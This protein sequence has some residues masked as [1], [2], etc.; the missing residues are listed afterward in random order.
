[1]DIAIP[2]S[3]VLARDKERSVSEVAD[4]G[5]WTFAAVKLGAQLEM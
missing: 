2:G 1:M 5:L 4:H 3:M